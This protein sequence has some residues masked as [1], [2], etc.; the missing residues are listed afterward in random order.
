MTG[1][2]RR[3]TSNVLEKLKAAGFVYSY[4]TPDGVKP[5]LEE[6]DG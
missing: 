5:W 4:I 6:K 1:T 3:G 2:V